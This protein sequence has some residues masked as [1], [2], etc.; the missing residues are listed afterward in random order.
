MTSPRAWSAAPERV[1]PLFRPPVCS[2]G[3]PSVQSDH[4]QIPSTAETPAGHGLRSLSRKTGAG[5]AAVPA[6]D[7]EAPGGVPRGVLEQKEDVSTRPG[8]MGTR[9]AVACRR[10]ACGGGLSLTSGRGLDPWLPAWLGG[11]P[12][13]AQRGP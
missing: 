1:V 9:P 2:P 12:A 4:E 3:D 6:G 8:D 11:I 5:R 7:A 13:G 10:R